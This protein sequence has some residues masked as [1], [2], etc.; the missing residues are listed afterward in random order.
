MEQQNGGVLSA[1]S[2]AVLTPFKTQGLATLQNFE[3]AGYL[4]GNSD[5]RAAVEA[6]EFP[7]GKAH[8]ET[9]GVHEGRQ[10]VFLRA[11]ADARAAKA[12]R[13]RPMLR[14]DMPHI[15]NENK[16][17]FLTEALRE[18]TR[19]I[20]T[21]NVSEN[22]Y[23][24]NAIALAERYKDGLLLDCGAGRRN[25]YYPNVVNFEIADYD[26]T[27]VLGVGEH[28]PFKDDSFDA[29]IS[30]AVLEHVR[31]PFRCAQ[32]IARVL[33]PGG[34]LYCSVPFL[35]PLHGY[36]HHYYNMSHQG[37]KA[38]FEDN[39]DILSQDVLPS[40]APIWSLTWFLSR[41]AEQLPDSIRKAFLSKTVGELVADPASYLNEEWVTA[42]P[43]EAQF[44]LASAT[45]LYARKPT[46]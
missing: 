20:N 46:L 28:L 7:S 2:E 8:F 9:F 30:I 32:E 21:L 36:P 18:E 27:D 16:F 40:T 37:L 39:L 25:V 13:L 3:E 41:W 19:I 14:Q 4:A 26:T 10:Q 35:Q 31:D 34:E 45:V 43:K 38:L 44:E 23:D 17:N 12:E 5:I 11:I 6:G 24:G 15:E 42:L 22:D 33:K 1:G 29:V